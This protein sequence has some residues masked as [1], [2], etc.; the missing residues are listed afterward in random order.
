MKK[1]ALLTLLVAAA[2]LLNAGCAASGSIKP[3]S[4]VTPA[5]S[6]QVGYATAPSK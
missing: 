6:V 3:T 2:A 4:S 5:T 1:L